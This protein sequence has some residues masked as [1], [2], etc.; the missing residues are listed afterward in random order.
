MKKRTWSKPLVAAVGVVAALTPAA[1]ARALDCASFTSET[2][3]LE[4]V[5]VTED[6]A[7]A[8]DTQDYQD[9]DVF[10]QGSPYSGSNGFELFA[11]TGD[12]KTWKE[13]YQ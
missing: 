8:A 13:H 11:V 12:G 1:P 9:F 5:S 10:L 3:T 7:P 4:L 2:I 6:G